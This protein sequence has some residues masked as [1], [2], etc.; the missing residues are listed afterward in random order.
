MCFLRCP[1][2]PCPG[3][4]GHWDRGRQPSWPAPGH[5]H[6]TW[7]WLCGQSWACFRA[8]CSRSPRLN[9]LYWWQ[10]QPQCHGVAGGSAEP[11]QGWLSWQRLNVPRG[12]GRSHNNYLPVGYPA[13]ERSGMVFSSRGSPVRPHATPVLPWF[14]LHM[15][16]GRSTGLTALLGLGQPFSGK[17][18]PPACCP[19]SCWKSLS[20]VGPSPRNFSET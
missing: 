15:L 20:I 14:C 16:L 6:T 7:A 12:L 8:T 1:S 2:T 10:H 18:A 19:P 4:A 11:G 3:K 9:K 13:L 5:G 17:P